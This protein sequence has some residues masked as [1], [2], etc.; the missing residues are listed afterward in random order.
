MEQDRI[1]EQIDAC[2]S[3]HN[4]LELPEMSQLAQRLE[5]DG[6]LR[7]RYR[8]AMEF[9]AALGEA[10]HD[11]PVPDGLAERLLVKLEDAQAQAVPQEL[12]TQRTSRRALWTSLLTAAVVLAVAFGFW[13]YYSVPSEIDQAQIHDLALKQF[14]SELGATSLNRLPGPGDLSP[15]GV[16]LRLIQG[17]SQTTFAYRNAVAY[18]LKAPNGKRAIL[19]V[20]PTTGRPHVPNWLPVSPVVSQSALVTGKVC[21][22]WASGNRLF[23][24]VVEGVHPFDLDRFIRTSHAT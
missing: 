23:V 13:K 10:M 22:A 20:T 17:W 19:F 5:E 11:V 21:T 12:P 24:L 6:E 14:P 4:D 3:G 15:S 2:R 9:D 8:R 16:N 18:H 1:L 7:Q